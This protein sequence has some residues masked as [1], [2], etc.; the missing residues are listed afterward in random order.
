M[1]GKIIVISQDVG[2]Y[3]SIKKCISK[4]FEIVY[5]SFPYAGDELIGPTILYIIKDSIF[6]E[7]SLCAVENI[8]LRDDFAPILLLSEQIEREQSVKEKVRAIAA[9]VDEYLAYPQTTEEII[10]SMRALI[11]R[12]QRI[13][14]GNT[15]S[16]KQGFIINPGSRKIYLKGEEILFTKLEF[17]IIYYLASNQNRV[18]TYKELYEAV[19]HGKY[20]C[21]D[22]NIM[23]H[24]HRIRQK[25]ESDPK[26]PEIIQNVYGIGYRFVS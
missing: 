18:I 24:I 1:F 9:G 16:I 10:A 20:L 3:H 12:T 17:D 25:L 2:L 4:Q 5:Q 21:D 15:L 6:T 19:W 13:L 7:R 22:M 14:D 26:H 23:A 11:R 8:R